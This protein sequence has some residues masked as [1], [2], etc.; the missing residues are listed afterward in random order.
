MIKK[1][2]V[3]A[4]KGTL[5]LIGEIL[6]A[7]VYKM[8]ALISKGRAHNVATQKDL[9]NGGIS[10]NI[11]LMKRTGSENNNRA[12]ATRYSSR[13]ASTRLVKASLVANKKA[14]NRE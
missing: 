14:V 8:I 5:R 11:K 6:R 2:G 1:I 7:F 9:F 12:H 3:K 4:R 13:N 10:I